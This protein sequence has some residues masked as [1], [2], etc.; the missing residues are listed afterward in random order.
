MLNHRS[1]TGRGMLELGGGVLLGQRRRTD[2]AGRTTAAIT[3]LTATVGYRNQSTRGGFLFRIGF[4]PFYSLNDGEHAYPDPD[5]TP[6][7][8]VSI[9]YGFR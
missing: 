9:G 8:G 5:F 7:A 1:G 3:T 4:T 6:S 2:E